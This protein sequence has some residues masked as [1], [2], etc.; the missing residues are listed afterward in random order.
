MAATTP[1]SSPLV[2]V[3][4]WHSPA[5]WTTP[6]LTPSTMPGARPCGPPVI[7]RIQPGAGGTLKPQLRLTSATSAA[8]R[9]LCGTRT[10]LALAVLRR[11]TKLIVPES[12]NSRLPNPKPV[13]APASFWNLALPVVSET[14][15]R[16][17]PHPRQTAPIL[18]AGKTQ[19]GM[20][21]EATRD[22]LRWCTSC[23][24]PAHSSLWSRH[25]R[26]ERHGEHL[27]A[28]VLAATRGEH[29][30]RS[31]RVRIRW[32]QWPLRGEWTMERRRRILVVI[33]CNYF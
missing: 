16:R 28:T 30:R 18:S 25:R 6:S 20:F 31:C 17:L 26:R 32:S 12:T 4:A 15:Y 11:S 22:A 8:V 33:V 21:G 27:R 9:T 19:V 14:I 24:R 13:A 23:R 5:A 3:S 10:N 1:T 2:S 29:W 7:R